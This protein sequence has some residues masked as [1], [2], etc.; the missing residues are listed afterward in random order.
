[1]L[2]QSLSFFVFFV[3]VTLHYY[4]S[5][6]LLRVCSSLIAVIYPSL[7]FGISLEALSY[8]L[9][10]GISLAITALLRRTGAELA[11]K[12][13]L[14]LLASLIFYTTFSPSMTLL[15][16]CMAGIVYPAALVIHGTQAKACKSLLLAVSLL[17]TASF[18]CFL[19]TAIS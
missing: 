19:N 5:P 3:I 9:L 16:L 11:A 17:A 12:K 7:A 2:F 18:L 8:T 10:A 1:M 13:T 6:L 15:L 14:L 4:R